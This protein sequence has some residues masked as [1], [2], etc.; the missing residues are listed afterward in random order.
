MDGDGSSHNDAVQRKRKRNCVACVCQRIMLSSERNTHT[1]RKAPREL[2][3]ASS[4]TRSPVRIESSL[5]RERD[6][7]QTRFENEQF[8]SL[9]EI[10]SSSR[11][12]IGFIS[13]D[14]PD[15]SQVSPFPRS[16]FPLDFSFA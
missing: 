7:L 15:S 1:G 10:T 9:P 14:R 2:I 8:N 6:M 16:S 13:T 11:S 5:P 3:M 4:R 12:H